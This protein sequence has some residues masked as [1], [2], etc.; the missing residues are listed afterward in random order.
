[1]LG[2]LAS[3]YHRE[4]AV[5]P[6]LGWNDPGGHGWQMTSSVLKLPA[7]HM[8]FVGEGVGLFDGFEELGIEDGILEG[9]GDSRISS[10]GG[11]RVANSVTSTASIA[12]LPSC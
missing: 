9:A 10:S 4:H 2:E 3:S 1:M 8:T 7:W 5:A 6:G 12:T 11:F